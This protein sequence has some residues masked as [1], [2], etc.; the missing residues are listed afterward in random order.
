[1]RLKNVQR[2]DVERPLVRGLQIHRAR[3]AR[4]NGKEPRPCTYTPGV[5]GF[6]AGKVESRRWRD[7]VVAHVSGKF[8][9]VIVKHTAHGVRPVIVVVRVAASV[10]V[11]SGQRVL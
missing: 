4:I 10:P 8:K 1:M 2:N 5:T 6:Q 3:L 11:P 9:E 7:E